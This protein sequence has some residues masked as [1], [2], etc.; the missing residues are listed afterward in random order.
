MGRRIL[1]YLAV[2]SGSLLFWCL[3][4]FLFANS[5][6][7]TCIRPPGRNPACKISKALLGTV[8]ISVRTVDDVTGI[9]RDRTCDEGCSYRALLITS[10]GA[11][12]PLNDVYTD[13]AP[14]TKQIASFRSFLDGTAPTYE[15]TAPVPWW[16]VA[17]VGALGGIELVW[18]AVS[19]V[20]GL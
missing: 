15:D 11:S 3:F 20:R 5:L 4:I 14:V 6:S 8:Q 2:L 16:V 12:V 9:E 19:F 13:E 10:S 7:V 1:V 18:L 17:L